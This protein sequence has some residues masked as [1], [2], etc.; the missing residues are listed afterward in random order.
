MS[1]P[2]RPPALVCA[3][4]V[5]G[6]HNLVQNFVL[7][8]T[9]YVTGNLAVTAVT[10]G[11]GRSSG[12]SWDEMG[13]GRPEFE[14]SSRVG[15]IAAAVAAAGAIAA[16][17][18]PRTRDLLRDD[19]AQAANPGEIARRALIRFPLGTAMFEEIAFRGV[20]PALMPGGTWRADAL[21]AGVFA[22]WHLIPTARVQAGNPTSRGRP[23]RHRVA[24]VLAGSAAAGV[25]GFG[26]SRLRRRTGSLVA[27]WMVHAS[28]NSIAFLAGVTAHSIND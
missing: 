7:R 19:R 23:R 24:G 25:A 16:M 14:P 27:P 12:A 4:G 8:E 20:L 2:S 6:A 18:H 9:G 10:V 11:I 3:L 17:A 5:L 1:P 15:G 26:L 28:V 22:L 13:L 21:S